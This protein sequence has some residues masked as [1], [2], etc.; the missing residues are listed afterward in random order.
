MTS[1]RLGEILTL[2]VEHEFS[3]GGYRDVDFVVPHATLR[4]LRRGRLIARADEGNLTEDSSGT[5]RCKGIESKLSRS[6]STTRYF[7]SSN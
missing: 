1:L 6:R 4:Q 3:G 5:S 7:N 2:G